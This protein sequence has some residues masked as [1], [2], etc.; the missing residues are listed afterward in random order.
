MTRLAALKVQQTL[1]QRAWQTEEGQ[2]NS[3]RPYFQPSVEVFGFNFDLKITR[4]VARVKLAKYQNHEVHGC[5]MLNIYC[6]KT[7]DVIIHQRILL[8]L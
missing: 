3:V 1:L 6:C 8:T 7:I 4:A 5:E 2:N